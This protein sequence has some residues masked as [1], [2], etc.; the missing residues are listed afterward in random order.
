M[1]AVGDVA[2]RDLFARP[3][4][5]QRRPHLAADV[6][7]QRRHGVG[8]AATAAAP[9]RSCRTSR[10]GC[11][12]S[13]RPRPSSWSSAAPSASRSGPRCSSTSCGG[14]AIV[15]GGHRR[16]RGE[17]RHAAPRAGR[18]RRS[19]TP[20]GRHRAGGSSP[21]RRRRCGPRS[22]AATPGLDAQRRSART[23]PTPSTQ[24]LADARAL[25]AAVQ[26]GRQLRG[27]RDR[28][29]R[30]SQSSRSSVHAPDGDPPH[31]RARCVPVRVSTETRTGLPSGVEP[32]GR[33]AADRRR[34]RCTPRAAIPSAS[35]RWRK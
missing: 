27:P 34:G 29:P 12:G 11:C 31:P 15:P 32:P 28:S 8:A 10:R 24:L 26:P 6:A 19:R 30:R 17:A 13:T 1:H 33:A 14:K 18:P 22:G 20:V 4:R 21:A 23:P 3:P 35:R 16:V 2:D 25:V 7:V 9:A 5:P